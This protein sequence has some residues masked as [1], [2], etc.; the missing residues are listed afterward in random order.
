MAKHEEIKFAE[1]VKKMT[2]EEIG[3]ELKNQREKLYTLRSQAVTEKVENVAQFGIARRNIARLLTEESARR[4]SGK[5][6]P[7]HPAKAPVKKGAKRTAK[8]VAKPA[9]KPTHKVAKR[10]VTAAGKSAHKAATKRT[11]TVSKRKAKSAK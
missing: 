9:K 5:G 4:I 2:G 11:K 7:R 6:E 3:I 1:S 10:P 8:R